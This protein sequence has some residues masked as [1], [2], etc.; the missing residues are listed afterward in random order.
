MDPERAHLN[1]DLTFYSL[2]GILQSGMWL[3]ADIESYLAPFGLSHGRFSILLSVIDAG[4]SCRI[5]SDIAN[6]LGVSKG[7]V[8]KMVDRL[9]RD[10]HLTFREVAG[11]RRQKQYALTPKGRRLVNKIVPGYMARLH[12]M[13]A[14]VS[15]FEKQ[16]LIAILSKINFIDARKSILR[17][18][19]RTITERGKE[20]RERCRRGS[21]PDIDRV[22][23]LLH[24][25]ADLPTTKIVD[26]YLGTVSSEE[27]AARIKHYLF[28]GT[29]MQRNYATLFFARRNDWPLVNQAFSMGLIDYIQAYSR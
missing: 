18:H 24:E 9:V 15:P 11:D 7:T 2:L 19:Q 17:E 25:R 3:Q 5:G 6:S 23:S 26:Y 21:A 10:E 22:M 20:I 27:G 4:D 13:S 28:H 29:Q 16:Q 8:A 12:I 1:D 14:G